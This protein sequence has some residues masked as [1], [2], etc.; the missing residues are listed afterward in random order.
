M[1]RPP[2]R[3]EAYVDHVDFRS[4]VARV[5]DSEGDIVGS[6]F[7]VRV[8]DDSCALL[9]CAH[10]VDA[11]IMTAQD[12]PSTIPLDGQ[13]IVFYLPHASTEALIAVLP[14]LYPTQ[15]ALLSRFPEIE[16]VTRLEIRSPLPKSLEP[17]TPT[18]FS[19]IRSSDA[20]VRMWSYARD[21]G[22][23]AVGSIHHHDDKQIHIV[24]DNPQADFVESGFSGAPVFSERERRVVGM[25]TRADLSHGKRMAFAVPV[26]ALQRAFPP[27]AEP[28]PGMRAFTEEAQKFFFG[29]EVFVNKL[30]KS[31]RARP[32]TLVIGESGSGKSSAVMA[33]LIPRLDDDGENAII[34]FRVGDDPFGNFASA[35]AE[36]LMPGNSGMDRVERVRN[37]GN[38]LKDPDQRSPYFRE[39]LRAVGKSRQLLVFV[40]QMENVFGSESETPGEQRDGL[41][42]VA[43]TFLDMLASEGAPD[44]Q[45]RW[46]VT[47]RV[48]FLGSL[49]R[50]AA[51][52][53]HWRK[54]IEFIP[55]MTIKELRDAVVKPAMSLG[56]E[57]EPGVENRAYDGLDERI[58]AEIKGDGGILPVLQH[59]MSVLWREQDVESR[60]LTHDAFDAIGG[61][62]GA[63][64]R[65]ADDV[66]RNLSTEEQEA[67]RRL[68]TRLVVLGENQGDIRRAVD[69]DDMNDSDRRIVEVLSEQRLIVMSGASEKRTVEV[70]HDSLIRGWPRLRKW[71]SQHREFY[72]WRQRL[73]ERIQQWKAHGDGELLRSRALEEAENWLEGHKADLDSTQIEYIDRSSRGEEARK[74]RDRRRKTV[75]KTVLVILLTIAIGTAALF[76]TLYSLLREANEGYRDALGSAQQFAAGVAD[77]LRLRG[78]YVSALLVARDTMPQNLEVRGRLRGAIE[79]RAALS[80]A[81]GDLIG[82]PGVLRG[83]TRAVHTVAYSSNGGRILTVSYDNSARVWDALNGSNIGVLLGGESEIIHASHSVSGTRIVVITNDGTVKVWEPG[84]GSVDVLVQGIEP[85][86]WAV[87]SPDGTKAVTGNL[88]GVTRVW[89]VDDGS[90]HFSIPLG[91]GPVV[92]AVWSPDA[93]RM[94]TV[95]DDGI[96]RAWDANTGDFRFVLEGHDGRVRSVSFSDDGRAIVTTSFGNR[97][98]VWDGESGKVISVLE[99]QSGMVRSAT[100]SPDGTRIVTGSFGEWAEVWTARTGTREFVLNGHWGGVRSAAYSPDGDRIVT[101]DYGGVI[102]VW[103]ANSGTLLGISYGHREAIMAVAYAPDGKQVVSA[104]EDRTARLWDSGKMSEYLL[105]SSHN[106]SVQHAV[107]SPDGEQ[108]V[109]SSL[110]GKAVVWDSRSGE[111]LHVLRGHKEGVLS[112]AYSNGGAEVATASEDGT[113]RVWHAST[114]ELKHVLEVGGERSGGWSFGTGSVWYVGYA[115]D[116]RRIVTG[117]T[118]GLVRIWDAEE[119]ELLGV[120]E[121][122]MVEVYSVG[123]SPDGSRLATA[124]F[125][126]NVYVWDVDRGAIVQILKGHGESVMSA[127]YSADGGRIVSASLD[128][129][130]RVWDA[131]TGESTATLEGHGDDVVFAMFSPEGDRIVTASADHTARIWDSASGA[132]EHVLNGHMDQVVYAE[133]APGGERVVTASLDGQ[134]RVWDVQTGGLTQVLQSNEGRVLHA[135]FSPDGERVVG[136]L[137]RGYARVWKLSPADQEVLVEMA[138]SIVPYEMS[139][140]DRREIVRESD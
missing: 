53:A 51:F 16:D 40:D 36:Y 82:N 137:S 26:E 134:A 10:V 97:A 35:M 128:N 46:I 120:F 65:H 42:D 138:Y 45:L 125:A 54:S 131:V 92:S 103:D 70:V 136:A 3:M 5:H 25:V 61:I 31:V 78:E 74:E 77:Q 84:D 30:C 81:L 116:D 7:V 63:I 99:S 29:R 135:A 89:D 11:A 93:T 140:D 33:G 139:R 94:V 67:A 127:K 105:L 108:I 107:Y 130:A 85:I 66:F 109:T 13:E 37:L 21:D 102:R 133:F 95:H 44:K 79:G 48:D 19:Y 4:P 71:L 129:T 101:A 132:V 2:Y 12:V 55:P 75:R 22:V 8:N 6:G 100:Y 56:V 64:G 59:A 91:E 90:T 69:Y 113:V 118:D 28:Y 72:V 32:V 49:M 18:H 57:F 123:M 1:T 126:E 38:A 121:N 43:T 96:A 117:S 58:I 115:A 86:R 52:Q 60:L 23:L 20:Y 106:D 119:G 112:A 24:G 83:H 9:T 87:R 80:R 104:S 41:S 15:S 34:R 111:L 17:V 27:I 47:L 68:F 62:R 88:D 110:D 73:G 124:S 14:P 122:D 98:H 76:A 50:H 114:G 39:L